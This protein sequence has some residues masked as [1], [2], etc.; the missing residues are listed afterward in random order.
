MSLTNLKDQL[1]EYAKD[2]KLNVSSLLNNTLLTEQ[3]LWGTILVSA[4]A[5]RN[6]AVLEAVQLDAKEKLSEAAFNAAGSAAAIMAMNNIYYRFVHLAE[7]T[8]YRQLPAGLRMNILANP[9]VDK[10]DF[11]LWS[12][13]VSI[14]NGC[15]KC[16]DAHEHQLRKHGMTT[17]QVQAIAKVAAVIH[18]LAVTLEASQEV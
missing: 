14:I 9:G 12:L 6:R 13:A 2:I 18:S 16:I 3:Q 4:I 15:G 7:N 17:E 1:P 10:V 11:E 5:A 8:E